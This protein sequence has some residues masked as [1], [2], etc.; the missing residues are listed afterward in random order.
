MNPLEILVAA[1][2]EAFTGA[3]LGDSFAEDEDVTSPPCG[4]TFGMIRRARLALPA[5]TPRV[6]SEHAGECDCGDP[7]TRDCLTRGCARRRN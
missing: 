1:V 7:D 5:S 2:E 6:A 3:D 4:I